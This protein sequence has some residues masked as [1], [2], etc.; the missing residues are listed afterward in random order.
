LAEK[1]WIARL[2][3]FLQFNEEDILQDSG[4]VSHEVAIALAESEYE[5]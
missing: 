1:Y 5:K 2:D 3:A 4:K